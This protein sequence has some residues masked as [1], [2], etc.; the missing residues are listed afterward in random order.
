LSKSNSIES[1][2]YTIRP[3]GRHI[4][5]IGKDLIKDN[6]AAVI[7]LV[8]NAYDADSKS[9]DIVFSTFIKTIKI[10]GKNQ[11]VSW[12]KIV[13]KDTGHGMDFNTVVNKWMVPSTDDKLE[14]RISPDGR[15][16]QG[17][18][19]VGRY[20]VSI[21][22]N[23]LHLETVSKKGV[24]TAL[25][26]DWNEFKKKKYLEDVPIF[27]E[28]FDTEE[29]P[30]TTIEIIGDEERLS[31]WTQKEIDR[32]RFEL[33]K[34]ISPFPKELNETVFE[35]N[36]RFKEFPIEPYKDY[37]E[38]VEPFPIIDL[39]DY[40]ISGSISPNGKAKLLYE[41]NVIQGVRPEDL[42][43]QLELEDG[44]AFCGSMK[45]DIRVFDRDPESIQN[46]ID[47]GL[48]DPLTKKPLGR[49]DVK[50]LLNDYNGVGVYRNGFRIRPLG[51]PGYDWLELDKARVQNPSL[52]V[53]VDQIIGFIFIQDEETSHLEEKSARDGLKENKYY[54]GLKTITKT[55]INRLETRRFQFRIKVGR[56]RRRENTEQLIDFL[57]DFTDIKEPLIKELNNVGVK[58]DRKERIVEII[59]KKEAESNRIANILRDRIAIYQGQ[60]TLGKIVNVIL[61]EGRKPLSYFRNQIPVLLEWAEDLS[62]RFNKE[63]FSKLIDR[64]GTIVIQ[65]ELLTKLFARI[66][67]LAAKNRP[68]RKEFKMV[69]VVQTV[70]EVFEADLKTEGIE[71]HNEV[72][73]TMRFY[74]W[75]ADF[76]IM[77]TNL[78]ENSVF[79]LSNYKINNKKITVVGKRS[80]DKIFIDYE[81]NGPGI[82][83]KLLEDGVIFEPGFTTKTEG[84]GLGL[85]IAGEAM[86]RNQCKLKAIYSDG[87]AHFRIEQAI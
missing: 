19:G 25:L 37:Q 31:E 75:E 69:H 85:A 12:L 39:F 81:D 4:L 24:K 32:L 26:I 52:K 74:G 65:S 10:K 83:E 8:K 20:A 63:L 6:Y 56:G 77:L 44:E 84:T 66:D 71:F 68:K 17:R 23:E 30:G 82:D 46:L 5:T 72:E 7:E 86:E 40:R 33:K 53:G 57:F 51:D 54:D 35:I 36:L 27:I 50:R 73:P 28:A 16:M 55:V 60:A 64:V 2:Y 34:L 62:Q 47:R 59:E 78:V 41:N 22:G 61:H 70:F 15:L 1:G 29:T 67:P 21:L 49:L 79:W 43:F 48:K 38:K 76:Y 13:I 14:R 18:K 45:I 42:E 9:V 58:K 3:A 11:E 87:G 80:E